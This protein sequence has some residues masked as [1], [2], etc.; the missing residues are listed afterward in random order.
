MP[1]AQWVMRLGAWEVL[2]EQLA[3]DGV[4]INGEE[5]K[6]GIVGGMMPIL[7]AKHGG[8]DDMLQSEVT[9]L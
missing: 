6:K 8:D 1:L 5:L 3:D 2:R 7:G 4:L 9:D